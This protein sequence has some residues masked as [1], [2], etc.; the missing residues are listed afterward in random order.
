MFPRFGGDRALKSGYMRR[1]VSF[2][3]HSSLGR[4]PHL[5][6]TQFGNVRETKTLPFGASR[7]SSGR[8]TSERNETFRGPRRHNPTIRPPVKTAS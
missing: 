8:E 5:R 4:F 3:P 6:F 2:V 1:V 7:A